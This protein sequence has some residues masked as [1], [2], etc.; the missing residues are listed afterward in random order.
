[1]RNFFTLLVIMI[2]VLLV[3]PVSAKNDAYVEDPLAEWGDIEAP[4]ELPAATVYKALHGHFGMNGDVDAF[5][6]TFE[7]GT[8]DWVI[9]M[10]VPVC[11]KHFESVY[12][13]VA[14]I[15]AG[16]EAPDAEELP[17]TLPEG[18]G[19]II[20]NSTRYETETRE[21][22]PQYY[23]IYEAAGRNTT[24]YYY[25][26][27]LTSV[28]IPAAGDYT[29]A[30]WEPDGHVG[31]YYLYVGNTHPDNMDEYRDFYELEQAFAAIGNGS[32][33]GQ[34]CAA[35]VVEE[36]CPE[37][38]VLIGQFPEHNFPERSRVGED[39][40]LTGTVYEA[41]TC[42]PVV[43]AKIEFEM[44]NADG[45]YDG[46]VTGTV[47]TNRQG[48]YRIDSIVLGR[49]DDVPAHIHLYISANGYEGAVTEHVLQDDAL[50]GQTDVSLRMES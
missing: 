8:E 36:D 20:L 26:P 33:M 44:T 15:G 29:L 27:T 47:Y 50:I 24:T 12:P 49:Y 35:P 1:M 13:S 22:D 48:S 2:V 18:Q 17:F 37:P 11:G 41:E 21:R 16:L 32:W 43:G 7:D 40:V 38:L 6:L 45:V 30:V 3:L 25:L 23:F 5:A 28:D 19:A 46:T 10:R 14:L 9:E 42:L 31:A 4:F 39:F 34:N